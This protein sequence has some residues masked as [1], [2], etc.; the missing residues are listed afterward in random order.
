MP[1]SVFTDRY[2]QFRLLLINARRAKQ[3]T[4]VQVAKLLERP[5]SFVSKYEQGE[6]RLDVVEFLDVAKALD[7]DISNF[8]QSL[9]KGTVAMSE[10]NNYEQLKIEQIAKELNQAS[11]TE[12]KRVLNTFERWSVT[13]EDIVELIDNNPSLRGMILGYVAELKLRK[14]WFSSAS[15]VFY[16]KPDDHNR[17]IKGDLI[18]TYKSR[19]FKIESKSLQTK[20]VKKINNKW[21]GKAQV[22]ASDSR[23]IILPDSTILKTTLLLYG[24]FDLL[25]VNC[26]E[27]GQEWRFAF[28]KNKDL[29]P[30]TYKKY[31][32]SQRQNLI[33]SLIA[34]T[35]PP[36]PPFYEDPYKL[37]DEIS[38]EGTP[39]SKAIIVDE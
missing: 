10:E 27:F 15:A 21:T 33:S 34:V 23:E 19:N 9:M 31:T 18:V 12:V 20:T 2:T 28:A 11:H 3:L 29:P 16:E 7:I 4:Q 35:W 37:L 14:V 8:L 26:F 5:Q 6:R 13:L 36:E 38:H 39:I 24:E 1:K 22:D 25:A 30:S 32:E 17:K